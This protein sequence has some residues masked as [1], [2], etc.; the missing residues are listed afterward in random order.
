MVKD[1]AG[2]YATVG[3]SGKNINFVFGKAAALNVSYTVKNLFTT[4]DPVLTFE[5]VLH[6]TVTAPEIELLRG[7]SLSD[8]D[9]AQA[10]MKIEGSTLQIDAFDL[11]KTWYIAK[12]A[13][14]EAK[15]VYATQAEGAVITDATLDWGTCDELSIVVTAQ[16][17]YGGKALGEPKTFTVSIADPIADATIASKTGNSSPK[18]MKMYAGCRYVAYIEAVNDVNVFDGSTNAQNTN[19]AVAATIEYGEAVV[20]IPDGRVKFDAESH[21]LTVVEGGDLELMKEITVTIPVKY[22]YTF[23]ER[24][25]QI[26]V[27]VTK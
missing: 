9:R 23:G 13:P 18:S 2:N 17:M 6:V 10:V 14:A 1:E 26:V 5:A 3:A 7:S 21:V 15:V 25:A 24:T 20:S 4:A 19:T 16:V 8:D 27:N 12:D 22:V 11:S